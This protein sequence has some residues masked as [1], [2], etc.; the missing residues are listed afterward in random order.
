MQISESTSIL[1]DAAIGFVAPLL[2]SIIRGRKWSDTAIIITT[3]VTALVLSL[4]VLWLTNSLTGEDL[5]RSVATILAV[6]FPSYKLLW[7]KTQLNTTLKRWNPLS[8][9]F[10]KKARRRKPRK[11]VSQ[12]NT[13][14]D[15]I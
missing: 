8:N 14:G 4:T 3:M 11:T 15:G 2:V 7:E 13:Q 1:L 12:E 6:L 5:Q 9:L 10:K